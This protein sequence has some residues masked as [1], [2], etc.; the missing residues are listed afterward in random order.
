MRNRTSVEASQHTGTSTSVRFL[1]LRL[2]LGGR[3]AK[4]PAG[5]GGSLQLQRVFMIRPWKVF[6][7]VAVGAAVLPCSA[8]AQAPTITITSPSGNSPYAKNANVPGAG[9]YSPE[10]SAP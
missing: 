4:V 8:M 5:P 9:W 7:S 3:H 1:C 2:T 6:L 10:N